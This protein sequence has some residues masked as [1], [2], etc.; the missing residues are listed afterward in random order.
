M[1]NNTFFGDLLSRH[2]IVLHETT[3]T[4]DY[5]LHLLTNSTPLPEYTA[6]MAKT[7]TKGRGQRGTTWHATPFSN[8]TCSIYLRPEGLPIGEQFFLTVIASLAIRDTVL[9][10]IDRSTSTYQ[11]AQ[12]HLCGQTK[13]GWYTHWKQ[14]CRKQHSRIGN[15][16]RPQHPGN[17]IPDGLTSTSGIVQTIESASGF[18]LFGHHPA[19]TTIYD[20]LP[21]YAQTRST[22]IVAAKV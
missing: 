14:T 8:L 12:R 7:Q 17:S 9:Q 15:W 16:N 20:A 19:Y 21:S 1:Q 3:S 18:L 13:I 10:Y 4:N 11:M 22:R 2:T 5:L 6:I